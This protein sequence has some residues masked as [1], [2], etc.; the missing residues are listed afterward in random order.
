MNKSFSQR[1]SNRREQGMALIAMC[2]ILLVSVSMLVLSS[3]K[4]SVMEQLISYNEYR[5]IEVNQAAEAGLEYGLAWYRQNVPAWGAGSSTLC[6]GSFN[7]F[8]TLNSPGITLPTIPAYNG[9]AYT[10]E[11]DYCRDKNDRSKL[12][13]AARATSTSDS[14]VTYTVR[15]YT[16]PLSEVL[17]PKFSGA[18]LVVDGCLSGVGGT[19]LIHPDQSLLPTP[20]VSVETSRD[21]ASAIIDGC[22]QDGAAWLGGGTVKH[23]AFPP[24]RS[25][26]YVFRI[27]RTELR[28][29]S[30]AEIAA[31]Y[32]YANRTY[33]FYESYAPTFN[34]D[35]G[36]IDHPVVIVF[37]GSSGC[38][39]I[40]GNITIWGTVYIDA[41]CPAASGWG[42]AFIHGSVIINGNAT[43][44]TANTQFYDWRT[45]HI[46]WRPR[47]LN[48]DAPMLT[49]TWSDF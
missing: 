42:A 10:L 48:E 34:T 30:D 46:N 44:L 32:T 5:A 17:S 9:D 41:P 22:Q 15:V 14:T 11:I 23:S 36:T 20:G 13:V 29:K 28:A 40:N 43:H 35:T 19:P 18:P 49:G 37:S 31:G 1:Y 21:Q 3:G 27:S 47:Y 39:K 6:W 12:Q 25:W 38:P 26:N 8:Y 7:E 24:N 2:L 45:D 4:T 16:E 33:F